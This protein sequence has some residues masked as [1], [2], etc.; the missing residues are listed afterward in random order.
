MMAFWGLLDGLKGVCDRW[1][2][3]A[4][5]RRRGSTHDILYN[6]H[7]TIDGAC[8]VMQLLQ[9]EDPQRQRLGLQCHFP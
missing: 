4:L 7:H 2:D 8:F 6:D 3:V 9:V 1:V 5:L